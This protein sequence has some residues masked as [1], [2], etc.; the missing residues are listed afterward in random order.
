M[1]LQ[2]LWTIIDNILMY[3]II[4]IVGIRCE[5]VGNL[6]LDSRLDDQFR[7]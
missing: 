1:Q 2:K 6:R 4:D 7:N 5:I 3:K